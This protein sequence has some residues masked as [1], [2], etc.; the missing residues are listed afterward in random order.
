TTRICAPSLHA[1]LPISAQLRRGTRAHDR[2]L[3]TPAALRHRA[4][5]RE[6]LGPGVREGI[7]AGAPRRGRRLELSA[8]MAQWHRLVRS[9]L[10]RSEEHTSELQSREK[11]V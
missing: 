4:R 6:A 11:L 2:T 3:R 9:R 1:A 5:R 7:R 8:R 10:R